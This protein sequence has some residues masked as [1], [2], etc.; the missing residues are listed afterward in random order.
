IKEKADAFKRNPDTSADAILDAVTARFLDSWQKQSGLST[1]RQ[2]VADTIA[3]RAS[4]GERVDMSV[5]EWLAF[6]ARASLYAAREKA[7]QL[8][9]DVEWDCEIVK[10]PEGYYQMQ[11]GLEYA[12]AK[13]LASAPFADLLWM[14]TATANLA[15]AKAYAEAIHAEFP[16]K[17]LAYNLSP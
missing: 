15:E 9:L 3:L 10:T 8:G 2:A 13:S 7:A 6:S 17:M 5:E 4:Q 12:I 11:G 1:Y 16:D 14:E